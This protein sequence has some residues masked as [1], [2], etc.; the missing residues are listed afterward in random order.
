M[1]IPEE[2][3]FSQALF[4]FMINNIILRLFGADQVAFGGK[5]GHAGHTPRVGD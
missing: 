2:L 5:L 3:V 1:A 4:N